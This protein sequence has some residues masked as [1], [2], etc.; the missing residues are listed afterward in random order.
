MRREVF[1]RRLP[2]LNM[3]E[4]ML[5]VGVLVAAVVFM[6]LPALG[7]A[8][9]GSRPLCPIYLRSLGTAFAVY[10]AGNSNDLPS[11]NVQLSSLCEQ[12]LGARDAIVEAALT[13]QAS[14]GGLSE[15]SVRK[16]MYCPANSK[17]VR[18]DLWAGRG[19]STWGYVCMN[20]RGAAGGMPAMFPA[21]RVPLRYISDLSKV[22][23][24]GEAILALDVVVT[25]KDTAPL[26]YVPKGTAVSFGSSH[27]AGL[28]PRGV[29]VLHA[30]GSVEW[31]PWD[32][33]TAVAVPQPG[34]GYFWFPG[35]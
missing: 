20:D 13:S 5:L 19:I 32:E 9:D 2:G 18:D 27:L 31:V 1:M 8:K 35:M 29:N 25:D 14:M 4:I 12:S 16:W 7:R 11:S 24:P 22:R 6:M 21:R 30:D 10:A 3:W 34:G 15:T 28:K 17:Q 33:K 23:Q 26:D